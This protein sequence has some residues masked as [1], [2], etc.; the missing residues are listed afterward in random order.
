MNFLW[1]YNK[2]KKLLFASQSTFMLISSTVLLPIPRTFTYLDALKNNYSFLLYSCI[3]YWFISVGLSCFIA[4]Y[5][6]MN[7]SLPTLRSVYFP[8]LDW[9]LK[10]TYFIC[11]QIYYSKMFVLFHEKAKD[12]QL[13]KIWDSIAVSKLWEILLVK[14]EYSPFYR[15]IYNTHTDNSCLGLCSIT[16]RLIK[17]DTTSGWKISGVLLS[18]IVLMAV[19]SSLMFLDVRFCVE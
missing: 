6:N 9:F 1:R 16:S 10:L 3:R 19:H 5:V 15:H 12:W 18:Y 11:L 8:R 2:W 17:L 4:Y 14:S 13:Q 7:F